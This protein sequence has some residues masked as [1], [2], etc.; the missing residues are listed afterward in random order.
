MAN[1]LDTPDLHHQAETAASG[2]PPLLVAAERVASTVSQGVHGRRRVGQGETFWQFRRYEFGDS[3]QLIDWRQSAKSDPVYV[4][5]M[6]WEAA[7]SVWLWADGSPSMDYAS[8]GGPLS[9]GWRAKV[10]AVALTSL[11]VR[12]GERIALMGTGMIPST[13]R[14]TLLRIATA[15]ERAETG[16]TG[17]LPG[18]EFVPRHGRVVLFGDFLAPLGE[19][20]KA[21]ARLSDHGVE[22]HLVQILDPAEETLPFDGRVEFEGPE[23]EGRIMIGRVESV[24]QAYREEL[25]HHQAGLDA[26]ARS[27]GWSLTRHM[28][29][30]PPETVLMTLY[31]LLS[32][33]IRH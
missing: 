20:R 7:Q 15:L 23:G 24:R 19:T 29:H 25:A 2:L 33:V 5:E 32:Q 4:R 10:L 21:I 28:T 12:A 17:S 31:Q 27:F 11:L 18:P 8:D 22:G 3:T 6:E 30:R 9:K 13:G 1:P 16:A 14:N 26:V